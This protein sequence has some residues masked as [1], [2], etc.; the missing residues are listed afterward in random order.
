MQLAKFRLPTG[1]VSVGIVR[2]ESVVPLVARRSAPI[3]ITEILED[4]NPARR[5]A[6]VMDAEVRPVALSDVALLPPIDRHEVWAA[7]VTYM[8]SKTARMEE[9]ESAATLYDR[10]YE[11]ERPELFFKATPHRVSGSGQPLRIRRDSRWNVPEP[12][13][14]LV[15]NSR[16]EWVGCTVGNDMSSRDIEGENPLYLPQAKI[17]DACCGL[18]PWITLR[19]DMP[20]ATEIGIHLA[21]H[22]AGAIAFDGRTSAGQM[23]R[24]FED[25]IGWLARDN[26]F[27]DGAVLLTGTGVVPT[28]DFTLLPGDVV[29]ITIDGI[30]TL[31]NPIVQA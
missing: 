19:D 30:G 27:P 26:S 1:E 10:I 6:V 18:G 20:P 31:S 24:S 9:S 14:A 5:V 2:G 11:A 12:E 17:Y 21:V 7:G 29:E 4:E 3:T 13:L 15:L 25:L 28:S 8:R 23:A 22:R 16:L